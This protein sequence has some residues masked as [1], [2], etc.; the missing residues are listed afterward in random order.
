MPK[1]QA[2]LVGQW[3]QRI[4]PD[5]R[6]TGQTGAKPLRLHR[7]LRHQ[8]V[9][10]RAGPAA[11]PGQDTEQKGE[12][13]PAEITPAPLMFAAGTDEPP[14]PEI[15]GKLR[16]LLR[17]DAH[18]SR[19]KRIGLHGIVDGVLTLSMPAGIAADRI[20]RDYAEAIK[21]AAETLGVFVDRVWLT[22]R[23]R[24]N[25]RNESAAA[26]FEVGWRTFEGVC[27]SR[28]LR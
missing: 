14:W 8:A 24:G 3:A 1:S 20:K 18:G 28:R 23:K 2:D 25:R 7:R 13:P 4:L 17:D 15:N 26:A 16:R 22:V 12:I 27:V 19:F 6:P 11:Q 21:M 9:R 10:R 5:E